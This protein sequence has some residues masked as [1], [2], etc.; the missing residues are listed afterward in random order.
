VTGSAVRR[1]NSDHAIA[2]E[3]RTSPVMESLHVRSYPAIGRRLESRGC[4]KAPITG[5]RYILAA[6]KSHVPGRPFSSND[7]RSENFRPAPATRS[8]TTREARTSFEPDCA[9]TRAAACRAIPPISRPRSSIS[10]VWSSARSGRPICW[11]AEG[12]ILSS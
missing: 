4:P 6:N 8:V 12:H 3:V 1:S 2:D 5:M 7:P 9:I 10:P 11:A